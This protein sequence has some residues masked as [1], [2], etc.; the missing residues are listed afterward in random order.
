MQGLNPRPLDETRA[1]I[2]A[3]DRQ[4]QSLFLKRMACSEQ[5]AAYKLSTGD[6]IL[7]PD[8]EQ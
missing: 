7:K 6:A 1:E 5:V 2:T 3:L 8:R 4:I